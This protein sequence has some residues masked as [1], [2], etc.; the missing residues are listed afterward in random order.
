VKTVSQASAG[1]EGLL[2]LFGSFTVHI[3][4]KEDARPKSREIHREIIWL[5]LI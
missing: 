5:M 3:T 2:S 1:P 4:I